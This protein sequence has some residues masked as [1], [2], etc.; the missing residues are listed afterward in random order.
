MMCVE[1]AARTSTQELWHAPLPIEE[2]HGVHAM[3]SA[4]QL[5]IFPSPRRYPAHLGCEGPGSS[6]FLRLSLT[7]RPRAL[8]E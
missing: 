8:G 6:L 5:T 7:R 3:S 1:K 4:P 2:S